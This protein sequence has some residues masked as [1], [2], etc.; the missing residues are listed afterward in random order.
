MKIKYLY[1]ILVFAITGAIFYKF[2]YFLPCATN[3][4]NSWG[5]IVEVI[6]FLVVWGVIFLI[7][8]IARIYRN[9]SKKK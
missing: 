9:Y 6:V 3:A 7:D 5:C 4:N 2:L 1:L 8:G